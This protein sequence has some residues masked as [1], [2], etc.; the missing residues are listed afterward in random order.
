[1]SDAPAGP[2]EPQLLPIPAHFPVTWDA[3]EEERLDALLLSP[4][5]LESDAP[6]IPQSL[7]KQSGNKM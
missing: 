5:L 1:M 2:P 7:I 6:I 4:L 3:P